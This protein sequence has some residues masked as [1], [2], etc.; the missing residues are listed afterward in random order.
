MR[1]LQ[2]QFPD[3]SVILTKLAAQSCPCAPHSRSSAPIPGD[4][5]CIPGNTGLQTTR[6]QGKH[7]SSGL[8]QLTY[9]LH[10]LDLTPMCIPGNQE[11]QGH[12]QSGDNQMVKDQHKS[13]KNKRLGN[14]ATPEH[15]YH[16]IISPE[17]LNTAEEQEMIF[18][19]VS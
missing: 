13:T 19:P 16:T 4:L 18:S 17:N 8:T 11:P 15:K 7:S 9:T 14:M 2:T 12:G 3:R 5:Q 10:L 1:P 6:P